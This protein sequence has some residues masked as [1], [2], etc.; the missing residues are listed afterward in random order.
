MP[1]ILQACQEDEVAYEY[2]HGVTS[3]GAFTYALAQELRSDR[4]R[5]GIDANDLLD[6]VGERV[7]AMGYEQQPNLV[8]PE[9]IRNQVMKWCAKCG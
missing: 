1:I 3:F 2:R 6:G 5:K 9:V 4:A 8:G 7:E